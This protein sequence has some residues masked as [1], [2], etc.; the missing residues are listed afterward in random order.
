MWELRAKG[1]FWF[2][3]LPFV[4]CPRNCHVGRSSF[5]HPVS[6]H[7]FVFY[8]PPDPYTGNSVL[9]LPAILPQCLHCLP[10]YSPFPPLLWLL[11]SHW[12]VQ[13]QFPMTRIL[14]SCAFM[15]QFSSHCMEGSNNKQHRLGLC[16]TCFHKCPGSLGFTVL[17][18]C[19]K[20]VGNISCSQCLILREAKDS[21]IYADQNRFPKHLPA[22]FEQ[23]AHNCS[24]CT[25]DSTSKSW[26][27]YE[28]WFIFVVGQ[29]PVFP[30]GWSCV[31]PALIFSE[32][33]WEMLCPHL[34]I[35]D[36]FFQAV[37]TH[38]IQV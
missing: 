6:F 25:G 35:V 20:R 13:L 38:F 16:S 12:W 24:C 21:Y 5:T 11:P 18:G 1:E 30:L 8:L 26:V 19:G 28:V 36:F 27:E 7:T 32:L 31:N 34:Y 4:A 14:M 10:N 2:L 3:L 23:S 33:M 9:W 29:L 17:D 22:P 15:L 37:N